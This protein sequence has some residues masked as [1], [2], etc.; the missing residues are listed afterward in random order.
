M[1]NENGFENLLV[2]DNTQHV[3]ALATGFAGPGRESQRGK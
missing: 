2:N 3:P 1:F